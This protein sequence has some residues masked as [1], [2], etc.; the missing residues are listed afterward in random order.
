[1]DSNHRYPRRIF[2]AAPSIPQF[3]FRN[4]N[5]LP[6]DLDRGAENIAERDNVTHYAQR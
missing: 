2:L 5:R 3:T 6:R 4:I 1:M